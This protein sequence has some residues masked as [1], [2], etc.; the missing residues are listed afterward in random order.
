MA[1]I[2]SMQQALR[3][4]HSVKYSAIVRRAGYKPAPGGA[5]VLTSPKW[6]DEVE[7]QLRLRNRLWEGIWEL[8]GGE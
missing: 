7:V 3:E 8:H 2:I 4:R 1:K 6:I 5:P